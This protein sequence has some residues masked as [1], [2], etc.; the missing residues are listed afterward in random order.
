MERGNIWRW[1]QIFVELH[2]LGDEVPEQHWESICVALFGAWFEC[3]IR[4][5]VSRRTRRE[6]SKQEL[7]PGSFSL[8]SLQFQTLCDIVCL[9][10][11]VGH[12]RLTVTR[13]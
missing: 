8:G 10:D 1:E 11:S 5:V 6:Q 3:S 13:G 4:G 7:V 2:C 12:T 9:A